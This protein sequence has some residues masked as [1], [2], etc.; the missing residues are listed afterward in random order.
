MMCTYQTA[1][2]ITWRALVPVRLVEC[3]PSAV[4]CLVARPYHVAIK[5]S[6]L[7]KSNDRKEAVNM[8]VCHMERQDYLAVLEPQVRLLAGF[9]AVHGTIISNKGRPFCE[10]AYECRNFRTK[11]MC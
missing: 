5:A 8:I 9:A 2:L 1:E 6:R 10:W 3:C 7:H 11:C 4:P